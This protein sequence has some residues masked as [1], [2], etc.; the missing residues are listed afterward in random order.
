[1]ASVT[2]SMV[3]DERDCAAIVSDTGWVVAEGDMQKLTDAIIIALS[4]LKDHRKK[5]GEKAKKGISESYS[6]KNSAVQF[7]ECIEEKIGS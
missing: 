6:I 4:M 1:M 3:T 7:R 2:L 5:Q